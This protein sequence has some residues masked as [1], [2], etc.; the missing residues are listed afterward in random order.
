MAISWISFAQSWTKAIATNS[1]GYLDLALAIVN[2]HSILS[3]TCRQLLKIS[4]YLNTHTNLFTS[5]WFSYILWFFTQSL[6]IIISFFFHKKHTSARNSFHVKFI[7]NNKVCLKSYHNSQAIRFP[8][9]RLTSSTN[10]TQDT[11]NT[12]S[13]TNNNVNS[14]LISV[15]N[16]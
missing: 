3:I 5:C 16:L 6:I 7:Y 8:P 2:N 13:S 1:F 10:P 12:T 15:I 11:C 14:L 9:F 4:A